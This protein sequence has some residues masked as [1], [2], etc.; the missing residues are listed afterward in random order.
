MAL[1]KLFLGWID[2]KEHDI[3]DRYMQRVEAAF[4]KPKSGQRFMKL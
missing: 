1:V 3:N 4:F 2:T